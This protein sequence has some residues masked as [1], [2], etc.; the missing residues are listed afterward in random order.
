MNN[1][2][3]LPLRKL[4]ILVGRSLHTLRKWIRDGMPFERA[5][6]SNPRET[7]AVLV[8]ID[9]AREWVARDDRATAS[10]GVQRKRSEDRQRDMVPRLLET[11]AAGSKFHDAC[12]AV[13]IHPNTAKGWIRRGGGADV[14]V[15]RSAKE[16]A[17]Q[18]DADVV[19]SKMDRFLDHYRS[20]MDT[21]EALAAAGLSRYQVNNWKNLKRYP[22][23]AVW[24]S[25]ALHEASAPRQKPPRNKK[26]G[27][28]YFLQGVTGGCV[29][30]GFT[31]YDPRRRMADLQTGSPVVLRIIHTVDAPRSAERWAHERF[32]GSHSHGEWFRPTADLLDF[33]AQGGALHDQNQQELALMRA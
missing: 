31:M 14:T 23:L 7:G 8:D 2:T 22:E 15:L 20:G 13:G 12:V 4:S 29:K 18:A 24:F 19:R 17:N 32:S 26:L 16:T 3:L 33:I 25:A 30:I 1:E 5:V 28:V 6:V 9:V 21:A 11:M 27:C 10:G